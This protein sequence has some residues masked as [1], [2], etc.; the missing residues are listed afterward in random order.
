VR[1]PGDPGTRPGFFLTIDGP[2]GIGKS[3][4]VT[5]VAQRLA[6]AG[7]IVHVTTEPS[8]SPLGQ[9]TR[10]LAEEVHGEALA[11]LV[12][13]DRRHHLRTEIR[14]HLAQS[15][16]VVCDRYMASSLVLQR[17][18][19][20]DFDFIRAINAG[21]ELPDLA[22]LLTT[23]AA[24]ITDRLTTRGAH[25][26]F[27]RDPGNVQ[28]ELDLY[29]DAARILRALSVTVASIDIATASPD[30]VASLI[31]SASGLG[32]A[33]VAPIESGPAGQTAPTLDSPHEREHQPGHR[34]APDPA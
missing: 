9:A 5:A 23:D 34:R 6:E 26:R 20:V 30:E 8:H 7:H 31:L 24:T 10:H 19:G 29:Q 13:A 33:T 32:S 14:P 11:L 12:A 15:R 16:I 18:D 2:G 25:H 27:E 4:T 17:L 1:D 21:I 22:V 3:T 28:R